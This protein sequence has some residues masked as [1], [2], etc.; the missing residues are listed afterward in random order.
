MKI[1]I[2]YTSGDKM[3]KS[4]MITLLVQVILDARLACNLQDLELFMISV[5]IPEAGFSLIAGG[6]VYASV[7]E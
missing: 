3:S 6:A 5:S 7:S 1:K 4:K 2:V